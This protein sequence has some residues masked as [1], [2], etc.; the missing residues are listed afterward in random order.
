MEYTLG[1]FHW[2]VYRCVLSNFPIVNVYLH[3]QVPRITFHS[4]QSEMKVKYCQ[5]YLDVS[6]GVWSM[7]KILWNCDAFLPLCCLV[8]LSRFEKSILLSEINT[9]IHHCS[10]Y[11]SVKGDISYSYSC[12]SE[13]KLHSQWRVLGGSF[14]TCSVFDNWRFRRHVC[15]LCSD[16]GMSDYLVL[17]LNCG[18][19]SK[20]SI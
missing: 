6:I 18:E 11:R 20:L 1:T 14:W 15:I 2:P 9:P 7:C 19:R 5:K 13:H 12:R 16:D 8:K 17:V 4:T 3:E 10:K